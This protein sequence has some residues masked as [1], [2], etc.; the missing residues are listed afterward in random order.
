MN[1]RWDTAVHPMHGAVVVRTFTTR[2]EAAITTVTCTVCGCDLLPGSWSSMTNDEAEKNHE[3]MMR[4]I[5]AGW[6]DQA[7]KPC[8]SCQSRNASKASATTER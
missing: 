8:M 6:F 5:K 3:E 2:E 4:L 7:I 1:L